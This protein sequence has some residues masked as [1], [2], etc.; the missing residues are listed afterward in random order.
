MESIKHSLGAAAGCDL[1]V[2]L[3]FV[4]LDGQDG[5]GGGGVGVADAAAGRP[6]CLP[7]CL[8]ACLLH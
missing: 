3:R 6:T 2:L 4:V 7:A 8:A 1:L 5:G